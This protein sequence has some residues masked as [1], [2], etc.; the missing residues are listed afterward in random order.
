MW[1][2]KDTLIH[3]LLLSVVLVKARAVGSA[4]DGLPL[5][6]PSSRSKCW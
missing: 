5:P 2:G 4:G 1:K 3:I 6:F